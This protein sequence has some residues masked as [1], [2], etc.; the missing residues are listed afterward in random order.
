MKKLKLAAVLLMAALLLS[1]CTTG[2]LG[3]KAESQGSAQSA[4]ESQS[5]KEESAKEDSESQ[6]KESEESKAQASAD[7]STSSGKGKNSSSESQ[8]ESEEEQSAQEPES[9]D[10]DADM[11]ID[12]YGEFSDFVKYW[13]MGGNASDM[14]GESVKYQDMDYC[15]YSTE[16]IGSLADL[17]KRALELM[18]RDLFDSLQ[19]SIAYVDIDGVLH[20]PVSF[21]QGADS[22]YV[23]TECDAAKISENEYQL[24]AGD[25]YR[26]SAFI[27][28]A[29]PDEL[30]LRGETV[31]TYTFTKQGWRFSGR[32][33]QGKSSFAG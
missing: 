1:G 6:S 20:G 25:Y 28:G 29:D 31:C 23:R 18:T 27:E 32:D 17:E 8:G 10:M 4:D 3:S 7:E 5:G 21:G 11:V 22:D 2:A 9:G 30:V 19:Q 14:N 16:D 24:H 13:Y 26:A 12:A 33:Y 15:P